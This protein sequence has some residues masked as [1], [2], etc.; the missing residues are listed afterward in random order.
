MLNYEEELKKLAI[1]V[2]VIVLV[3][4]G[5][6]GAE[7]SLWDMIQ[8]RVNVE[9][10]HHGKI[11]GKGDNRRGCLGNATCHLSAEQE[12]GIGQHSG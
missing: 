8:L 12:E 5:E 6:K 11:M 4:E 10:Q 7:K 2:N 3:F 1:E 9:P